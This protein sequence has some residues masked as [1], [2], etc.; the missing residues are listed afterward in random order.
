[1]KTRTM[2]VACLAL[3]ALLAPTSAT[4]GITDGLGTWEGAG[5]TR[6]VAGADLGG[7]SVSITRRLVGAKVRSDGK[8]TLAS[9]QVIVIWQ[10]LEELGTSGYRVTSS[11]GV[12]GGHCFA[13]GICQSYEQRSDGHAFA[14]TI[15]R[16]APDELR[17]LMTE[18]E[19]GQAVRFTE[20]TLSKKP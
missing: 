4:A 15:V 8:V 13:N 19:K 3:G 18:L 20:Q 1:M 10:E 5:T 12:G 2:L 6:S 11:N 14:T 7:F 9:G 17:I 16:D